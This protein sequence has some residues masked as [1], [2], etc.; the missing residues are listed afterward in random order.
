MEQRES[1]GEQAI[2]VCLC[3]FVRL[4]RRARRRRR[5][6][7]RET[8]LWVAARSLSAIPLSHPFLSSLAHK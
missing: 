2:G 1:E 6:A 4:D 8:F 3:A 7:S 5:G